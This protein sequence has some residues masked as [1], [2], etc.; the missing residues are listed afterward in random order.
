VVGGAEDALVDDDHP[1]RRRVVGDVG[2]QR[3]PRGR[4]DRERR[5]ERVDGHRERGSGQELGRHADLDPAGGERRGRGRAASGGVDD[6]GAAVA[7]GAELAAELEAFGLL[8]GG[9]VALDGDAQD[10]LAGVGRRS[11][12]NDC[13]T[14]SGPRS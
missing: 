11:S 8:A 1:V 6:R 2:L 5:H 12:T 4:V 3:V 13:S 14:E 9:Q 10:E 7:D